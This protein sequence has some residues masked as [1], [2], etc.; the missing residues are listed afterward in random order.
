[1]LCEQIEKLLYLYWD[2]QLSKE[3]KDKVEEHIKS[4]S[5][6]SKKLTDLKLVQTQAKSTPVPEPPQT[7]WENFAWRVKHRIEQKP[8][9]GP[10]GRLSFL[11]GAIL[12][13]SP[14]KVKWATAIA[15]VVL[16][17]VVVK[18]FTSYEKI[19]V[20][21]IQQKV[22]VEKISTPPEAPKVETVTPGQ[23]KDVVTS[24]EKHMP[25]ANEVL[26]EV[27][28]HLEEPRSL[29]V[30]KE[31]GIQKETAT[32]AVMASKQ[33]KKSSQI[34]PEA[35]PQTKEKEYAGFQAPAI[36]I[37]DTPATALAEKS[38]LGVAATATAQDSLTEQG[39][40]KYIDAW[41]EFAKGKPKGEEKDKA[42]FN[43]GR[44]Y[45]TLC[46]IG[47]N[48]DEISKEALDSIR[49]FR[50]STATPA[51]QDSMDSILL[52]LE[53]LQKK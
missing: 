38:R 6:C 28:A 18:L 4:C 20:T 14:A 37:S 44:A 23:G 10:A 9:L 11:L 1:M 3:E 21:T 30:P 12:S 42:Y 53:T 7:Y 51:Y 29:A 45:A 5:A 43:M 34:L 52:R 47:K 46:D 22:E 36:S 40:R 8:R 13:Y 2:N 49:T 17:F 19:D 35:L 39:V 25:P 26:P 41:R 50:D 32:D 15:S 24:K 27:K 48:K 33:E 16:V 31:K